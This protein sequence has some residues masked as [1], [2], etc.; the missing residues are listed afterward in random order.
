MSDHTCTYCM[1]KGHRAHACP[2]RMHVEVHATDFA[3]L[4]APAR[5]PI[6]ASAI[7]LA[8]VYLLA[9]AVVGLRV[10]VWGV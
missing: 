8:A 3:P 2:K 6:P 4:S 7:A 10:F 9:L 1:A 5:R